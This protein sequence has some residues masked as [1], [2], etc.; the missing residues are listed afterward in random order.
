V[1]AVPVLA[2]SFLF[3]APGSLATVAAFALW[4]K[5]RARSPLHRMLFNLGMALLSAEGASWV[6]LGASQ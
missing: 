6:L 4:A 3:G 5:V 2:A 1:S